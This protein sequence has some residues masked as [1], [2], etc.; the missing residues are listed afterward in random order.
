MLLQDKQADKQT[1]ASKHITSWAVI[2]TSFVKLYVFFTMYMYQRTTL[3]I[4]LIRGKGEG[5][6]EGAI[7]LVSVD[8]TS[9]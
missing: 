4:Y 3:Y 7:V 5:A 8:Q 2:I 9:Q 1:N 6:I